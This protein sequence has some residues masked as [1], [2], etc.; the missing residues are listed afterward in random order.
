[1]L[2]KM[3]LQARLMSA[4]ILMGLLVFSVASLGWSGTS[5]LSQH[6]NTIGKNNLPSLEALWEINEGQTQIESSERAL[7]NLALTLPERRTELE[8]IKTAW[9]QINRGFKDYEAIPR[10]SDEDIA[11]QEMQQKWETWRT[12]HNQFLRLNE[13]FQ[14]LG[15]FNFIEA[16]ERQIGNSK[17]NST[18]LVKAKAA[19]QIF[20]QLNAQAKANRS[21]FKASE[22]STLKVVA[23]NRHQTFEATRNADQDKMQIQFVALIAM[24]L[25]PVIALILG[26]LLSRAIAKPLD[27]AI[28]E[29]I[30]TISASSNEIAA[31]M[32]Q[33]EQIAGAQAI[34][35]NQT[36]TTMDELNASS[37]VALSQAENT[38]QLAQQALTLTGDGAK[39]VRLALKEIA[40][41]QQ[42]VTAIASSMRR[43]SDQAD[44][45]G[46]I[47]VVVGE[48]ANKT[49][50]L[51]L[52]A[53]VEAVR[54][55]ENGKGFGVVASEIRKLADQSNACSE[56]IK[57]LV[58]QIQ[59]AVQST[60]ALTNQGMQSVKNSVK[61]TQKN[62]ST[63]KQ[64]AE[65]MQQVVVNNQKISL[66]AKQQAVAIS[67]VVMAMDS[68]NNGA[69]ETA[70]G[71]TQTKVSTQQL[72]QAAQHLQILGF[73]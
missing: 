38:A 9:K 32:E 53:A 47:S 39:A 4:F 19:A 2:R 44:Q 29:T 10:S 67:Q 65:A 48:L 17:N 68:I 15:I 70:S 27:K 45:I 41:L 61:V 58:K 54:A 57:A 25:G 50:M 5:R 31:T 24:I 73:R 56:K 20:K 30:N 51:A 62:A 49:N 33:Q 16:P 6:I 26:N 52:N 71:I 72:H 22:T 46:S 60:V 69:R 28:T 11:F 7:L 21:L 34:A 55:G 1:M 36:T 18:E 12:A 42:Q 64:V 59:S 14:Q 66:N 23:L 13:Q 8:R 37:Q 3:N 35:V 63:F 40:A 43:L